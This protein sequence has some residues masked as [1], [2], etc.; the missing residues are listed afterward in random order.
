MGGWVQYL[1]IF[2]GVIIVASLIRSAIHKARELRR[3][4]AQKLANE[5][6]MEVL[7]SD[8][9]NTLVVAGEINDRPSTLR[10]SNE[11]ASENKIAGGSSKSDK[12][13]LDELIVSVECRTTITFHV[14]NNVKTSFDND[15][16]L[17]VAL[18]AS[19]GLKLCSKQKEE[20]AFIFE[21]PET[22][23]CLIE[24]FQTTGANRLDV[25][26]NKISAFLI[27]SEELSL[28]PANVSGVLHA[29][30]KFAR[31]LEFIEEELRNSE[32]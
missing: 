19:S 8:N 20:T 5:L 1:I 4:K 24:L 22:V 13:D 27:E 30:D 3:R 10:Y 26:K 32:N 2:V 9:P 25:E 14:S 18:L 12:N 11:K 17:E 28:S 21:Q 23:Q 15:D 29:L 16:H 6:D 31:L 7:A